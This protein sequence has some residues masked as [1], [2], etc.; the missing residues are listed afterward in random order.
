MAGVVVVFADLLVSGR[1]F[2]EA[3]ATFLVNP[4]R[5]RLKEE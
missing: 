3:P 1:D 4:Y 2:D 5:E